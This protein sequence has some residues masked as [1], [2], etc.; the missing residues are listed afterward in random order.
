MDYCNVLYMGR[1]LKSI[2]EA[3]AGAKY[4]SISILQ[5]IHITLL[6]HQVHW[7]PLEKRA[8]CPHFGTLFSWN[9]QYIGPYPS[10]LYGLKNGWTTRFEGLAIVVSLCIYILCLFMLNWIFNVGFKM[11]CMFIVFI[12]IYIVLVLNCY[13]PSRII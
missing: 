11:G 3:I 13:E 10:G 4:G 12:Y 7:I 8:W 2:L 6:L 9:L 1:S 5:A